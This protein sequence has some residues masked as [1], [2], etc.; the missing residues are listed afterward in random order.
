M[1]E[2]SQTER[3]TEDRIW[4][5]TIICSRNIGFPAFLGRFVH[6]PWLR[7]SSFLGF[8]LLTIFIVHSLLYLNL[9]FDA[10]SLVSF[11]RRSCT[12]VVG[13]LPYKYVQYE[14]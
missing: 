11:D 12:H 8:H 4:E 5:Q 3:G 1:T 6:T 14:E 7:S 10:F 9:F 13:A 2:Q